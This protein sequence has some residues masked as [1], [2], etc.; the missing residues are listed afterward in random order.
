ML[1][2]VHQREEIMN[3]IDFLQYNSEENTEQTPEKQKKR[4]NAQILKSEDIG[5]IS[6]ILMTG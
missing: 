5:S 1:T 6:Y 3:E 2:L 4:T